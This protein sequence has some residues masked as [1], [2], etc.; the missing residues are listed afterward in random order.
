MEG[1]GADRGNGAR[2]AA[3]N[4][5][6]GGLNRPAIGLAEAA[7]SRLRAKLASKA[8]RL[9]FR[10]LMREGGVALF[11]K[12]KPHHS[13]SGYEVII[14]Q[15]LGPRT[16]FG[17]EYPAREGMP[18]SEEWGTHGWTYCDSEGARKRFAQLVAKRT[19]A[20]RFQHD[21]FSGTRLSPLASIT[22]ADEGIRCV[23]ATG[24]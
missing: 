7:I 13:R 17:R 10:Q 22:T 5:G 4:L 1:V 15:K 21:V 23:V 6:E 2:D 12:S 24:E 3:Q 9:S 8:A 20:G 18:G 19:P 14:G 16:C 11:E